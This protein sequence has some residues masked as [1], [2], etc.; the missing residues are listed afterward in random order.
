[1]QAA[2]AAKGVQL[3]SAVSASGAFSNREADLI[4]LVLENLIQ[5]AVDATPAGKK[6]RLGIFQEGGQVVMEVEDQGSG[7][8]P[9]M[10]ARLFA[11]CASSKAGGTGIGLAISQQLARHLGARLE[12]KLSTPQGCTFRLALCAAKSEQL[13]TSGLPPTS[14]GQPLNN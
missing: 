7:M 10:V 3:E 8:P 5:N 2:A 9:E 12:L 6:V 1:M 14:S 4:L 11:P 13:Q